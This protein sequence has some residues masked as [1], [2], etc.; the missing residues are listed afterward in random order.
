MGIKTKKQ[1]PPKEPTPREQAK[2]I[3][4]NLRI[5]EKIR[6]LRKDVYNMTLQDMCGKIGLSKPLLSQIE[7]GLVC[8]PLKTLALIFEVF[9]PDVDM[10]YIFLSDDYGNDEKA[11]TKKQLIKENL[12]KINKLSGAVEVLIR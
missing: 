12:D 3:V 1:K 8:P 10:R 11:Q 7:N 4:E 5:G 2:L 6:T 9:G